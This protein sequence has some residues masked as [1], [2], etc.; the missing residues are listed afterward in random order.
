[1]GPPI[2]RPPAQENHHEGDRLPVEL[3]LGESTG[4]ES[5]CL[6][7]RNNGGSGVVSRMTGLNSDF[8]ELGGSLPAGFFVEVC[9]DFLSIVWI[10]DSSG[11][12]PFGGRILLFTCFT[13]LH[14]GGIRGTSPAARYPVRCRCTQNSRENPRYSRHKC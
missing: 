2:E 11:F 7:C 10:R 1:M 8:S 3:E 14:R 9:L 6:P 5:P 12:D 4:V 13:R